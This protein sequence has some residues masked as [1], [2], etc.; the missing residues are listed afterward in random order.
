M[1]KIEYNAI[2]VYIGTGLKFW[3]WKIPSKQVV[4]PAKLWRQKVDG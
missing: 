2:F 3:D 4:L 1:Q